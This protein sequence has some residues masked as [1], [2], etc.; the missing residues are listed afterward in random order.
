MTKPLNLLIPAA[1]KGS[2]FLEVGVEVPKPLIPIWEIPMLVW[3]IAN[4]PLQSLDKVIILSQANHQLPAKLK[5]FSQK[6][7]VEIEFIEINFWTEG[8]AHSLEILLEGVAPN[9]PVICANSDQY[10]FSGLD[11]FTNAVRNGVSQGQILTMEASSN[12]WSYLGRD[13]E[14]KI[15]RVV[16]KE[17][18]SNEAT[19]GIYGWASSRLCHEAL[20]WQRATNQKVNGEFYVAPSYKLLIEQHLEIATHSI[21]LHGEGVHGLGTPSDLEH[22]LSLPKAQ[23]V[24][25]FMEKR[26]E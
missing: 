15:N 12:A 9:S 3:V 16:E 13:A 4:F 5:Y 26:F 2:R 8:P 14:G 18:I 7:D 25:R 11:E 21:G 19:V 10:V 1:G 24:R 20:S 17:Q 6:M 22:F 23:E